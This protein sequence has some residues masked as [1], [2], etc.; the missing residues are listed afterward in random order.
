MV[1][2][3]EVPC[4]FGEKKHT[5]G[6]P[7]HATPCVS[8]R[9]RVLELR[10]IATPGCSV[11]FNITSS[12]LTFTFKN[13][14]EPPF[15]ERQTALTQCI[16]PSPHPPK[17]TEMSLLPQLCEQWVWAVGSTSAILA[18][19]EWRLR[20]FILGV[21]LKIN[22]TESTFTYLVTIC[23]PSWF[24]CLFQ[25]RVLGLFSCLLSASG[26][27]RRLWVDMPYQR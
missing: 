27:L 11:T 14:P 26:F 1:A 10:S 3:Q 24:Q 8:A 13:N 22:R 4:R 18:A 19:V 21:S 23:A 2:K 12:D 25:L 17:H 9:V 7:C 20:L 15:R 16:F 6:R 5:S